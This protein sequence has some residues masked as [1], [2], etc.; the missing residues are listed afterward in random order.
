MLNKKFCERCVQRY[1]D[2]N[3]HKGHDVNYYMR[4]FNKCWEGDYCMCPHNREPI[5]LHVRNDNPPKAC[6]YILEYVVTR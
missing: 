4:E 5:N 6:P 3:F 1:A 2:E